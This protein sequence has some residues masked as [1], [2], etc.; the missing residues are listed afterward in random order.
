MTSVLLV[1]DDPRMQVL[2]RKV[3]E[4]QGYHVVVAAN[5]MEAAAAA[6]HE[7]FDVVLMDLEM[8]SVNGHQALRLIKA[9]QPSLPVVAVTAYA[10]AGDSERC[11]EEG[12]D[13][14]ISKP[15]DI[16]NLRALVARLA[17]M[18]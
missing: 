17:V 3:L 14:Y 9:Y 5:G 10:M 15:Y 16:A 11:R 12:F 2:G 8:P 1:D 18:R 13:D 6:G 4:R 7:R